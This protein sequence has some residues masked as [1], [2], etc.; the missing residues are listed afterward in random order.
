[1]YTFTDIYVYI[2]VDIK[3]VV[4]LKHHRYWKAMNLAN[5]I[6]KLFEVSASFNFFFFLAEC[7]KL[8]CF[9]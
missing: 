1:M 3:I 9:L 2:Y 8:L 4:G 6:S 5:N 7:N